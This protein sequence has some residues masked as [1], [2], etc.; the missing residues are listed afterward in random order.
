MFIRAYTEDPDTAMKILFFARDIRFGLGERRVFRVILKYLAEYRPRSVLR[1]LRKVP[2]FGRWDDIL[3]LLGTPCEYAAV[4]LISS[5]LDTD[6]KAAENGG[7]VSLMAKWLPSVNAGSADTARLGKYLAKRLGMKEEEYR[8]ALSRLRKKLR[9]IENNLRERDYS[10]DYSKVPSKAMYKYRSAFMRNDGTRY[11]QYLEGVIS[12]RSK[13]NTATLTPYDIVQSCLNGF[14]CRQ[15]TEEQERAVNVT[16]SQ[17]PDFCGG[18]RMLAVV[19]CSGSM[20]AYGSPLPA[21][22]ALS[23]GLY[24]AERNTGEFANHFINFSNRPRL[25]ELKGS[26]FTEK[27]HYAM[28]FN[29][30]LNTDLE[31]VFRLILNTAV[32]NSLPQSDLPE[33]LVIIS[34]MEFD[35]CVKNSDLTN[36]ENAKRMYSE[37]GYKLPKIVFWNVDSRNDQ[38]PVKINDNGVVL[39]SGFTPILFKMVAENTATPLAFMTQILNN[40]RYKCITAE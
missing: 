9:L 35:R 28:S 30:P 22:V 36:F 4:E 5:Q 17:L 7:N 6:L 10:F 27:L 26:T 33:A 20:Y 38:Q 18:Q 12:G 25:I 29:E 40:D 13:L 2:E 31:A 15:M 11:E 21:A 3:T 1:N 19:D 8:K 24:F 32:K 16:W 39:V 23:L 34:D 14:R 37:H